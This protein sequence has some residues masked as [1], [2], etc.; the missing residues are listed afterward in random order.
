M[1]LSRRAFLKLASLSTGA[2][3]LPPIP[4][5]EAPR[6]AQALGRATIGA[7]IYERP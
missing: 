6:Q 1:K 2:A 3:L 4:P 5:D 7:Y